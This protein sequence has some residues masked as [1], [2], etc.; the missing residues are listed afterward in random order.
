MK[1]WYKRINLQWKLRKSMHINCRNICHPN[2]HSLLSDKPCYSHPMIG[3]ILGNT[4]NTLQAHYC[5][6][7]S[8]SLCYFTTALLS[9]YLILESLFPLFLLNR[10]PP[11][12]LSWQE[13]ALHHPVVP[14]ANS[15][16]HPVRLKTE[17]P[18]H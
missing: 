14:W 11:L 16:W 6:T 9:H 10:Y 17:S 5:T 3:P 7:E 18:K 13:A 1:L 15:D 12:T 2:S 4:C 8:L